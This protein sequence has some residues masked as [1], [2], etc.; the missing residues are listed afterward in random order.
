MHQGNRRHHLFSVD[1]LVW[2][3]ADV[4][5]SL[6]GIAVIILL[7]WWF[8]DAKDWQEKFNHLAFEELGGYCLR[9]IIIPAIAY[10]IPAIIFIIVTII[11]WI[12][13]CTRCSYVGYRVPY[14]R[15]LA[16]YFGTA[17]GR[18]TGTEED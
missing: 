11:G 6:V 14:F 9:H 10:I 8:N 18:D 5:L 2:L 16:V 15:Q 3:R 4:I 17:T 12:L 13:W 7:V 1:D